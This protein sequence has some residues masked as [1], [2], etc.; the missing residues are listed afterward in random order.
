[1][2]L[3]SCLYY[4]LAFSANKSLSRKR[5]TQTGLSS[6]IAPL[7][8]L[9]T[10]SFVL[11]PSS[12]QAQ[13]A[14]IINPYS[15]SVS[16]IPEGSTQATT[17]TLG[18]PSVF[19]IAVTVSPSGTAYVAA[20]QFS[21]PGEIVAIN[22]TNASTVFSFQGTAMPLGFSSIAV[23]ADGTTIYGTGPDTSG[24]S[25]AAIL[26]GSTLTT[27]SDPNG[28]SIQAPIVLVGTRLFT[29]YYSQTLGTGLA[30]IDLPSQSLIDTTTGDYL[31]ANFAATPD[32]TQVYM[33]DTNGNLEVVSTTS[34]QVVQFFTNNFFSGVVVSP[35]GSKFYV[36]L[37]APNELN[38]YSTSTFALLASIPEVTNAGD[39]DITPDGT[40]VYVVNNDLGNANNSTVQ[41]ISTAT[42]TITAAIPIGAPGTGFMGI[43]IQPVT[44]VQIPSQPG[45][46]L[47]SGISSGQMCPLKC[48]ASDASK[49]GTST[50]GFSAGEPIDI[51]SGNM[52][53]QATD[54]TTAG[55]NPLAFTRSYNSRGN[56]G[57]TT[58][59]K[60]LGINW[61]SN[62]DRYLQL[63]SSQVIAERA[64]GQQLTFT[65]SGSAWTAA[66]DVDATLTHS[67]S[68]WKLKDYNDATE[69]Y[70]ATSAT[71]AQLSTV[72]T[73]NGYMQTLHYNGKKQL[74]TVT[75][76]YNRS[77]ILHY[78]SNGT[79]STVITPDTTTLTYGYTAGG[80]GSN[81]TSITYPTSPPSALTYVY[82]ENG[83]PPNALTGVIDENNNRYAT[84]EYDSNTHA[85]SSQLGTGPTAQIVGVSY[86]D[87][88]NTRT[89]TNPLGVQD[90]YSLTTLQNVPKVTSITRA[91]TNTTGAATRSFTY[92]TN[93]Y[94]ATATDWNGNQT[95][96]TNNAHGMPTKIVEPS[97]TTNIS[98]DPIFVHLP[99]EILTTGLNS[100]FV[101][102]T[103]GNL[104]TRTDED[105]TSQTVPYSTHGQTRT[106]TYTWNNFLL[107]S[108]QN[109]RT[110]VSAIT[111]YGYGPDGALTSITNA[112]SQATNLTQHTGGGRPL[113]IVDPNSVTTTLTYDGCQR[114]TSSAVTTSAG[115]LTTYYTIDPA[116]ELTKVT[117]PDGSFL[118]YAYDTAHRATQVTDTQ[119]NYVKYTLDP[120]GDITAIN[121]Y[122]SSNLLSYRHSA[123]F[124]ALGRMLADV[125]GVGQ[126]TTYSNYD[127]NGNV[128]TITDPLQHETTQLFDALNRLSQITDANKGITK[129]AYDTHDRITKVTDANAHATS[130]V[131]D[132]FGDAIQ[133]TSPDS[134]IT[135]YHYDGDAN[136]TQKVDALSVTTTYAYDKLDRS[137]TRTYPADATQNVT[138]TYDETGTGFGF[139]I[140][141]LG[142][143]AD[144]AG[145][146]SISYD[147][148]GNVLST[149]R[150]STG[151]TNLSNTYYAYDLASRVTAITYP[152]GMSLT[153]DRDTVGNIWKVTVL[154]PGS[155]TQQTVATAAYQP[156]GPI[157][158]LTY[159]DNETSTRK[160]DLDYRMS[161]I[162]DENSTS[163][164]LMDLTYF[165]D[166]A[167]NLKIVQDNVTSGNSQF[168]G[169]DVLNRLSGALGNYGG[170]AWNY[171]KVGTLR[172]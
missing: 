116:S 45:Q 19:P 110:D 95:A 169:Y 102:D 32:G 154:P 75:D 27:I 130:Y 136:L 68:A 119:N 139:G 37:S 44:G 146:V 155:T 105:T 132:G 85:T 28:G 23:S 2:L 46:L 162:T 128:Q 54:Y 83:A 5:R 10:M 69:T 122:N 12:T 124:D 87:G 39:V 88:A 142:T 48:N 148:R 151:G 114:L 106:W 129:F 134:G 26:A 50:G 20:D 66:S 121:T 143:M 168:L 6:R 170:F 91:S 67:G 61:R 152:S 157:N 56:I 171:D 149:Q 36:G 35:D 18:P 22:G 118:A 7:C 111:N 34:F 40:T 158:S 115:I 11:W 81:L 103:S 21:G 9:A 53:Y 78:N 167:N 140:G 127:D 150:Y 55:Q 59:A 49:T 77:L 24:A 156:F 112:L 41:T 160:F 86:D 31:A 58:L 33:T 138:Y 57:V 25:V 153:Y 93:G 161:E 72:Q 62:Y 92:D 84:W 172:L 131:Y 96:Y 166:A 135:V 16:V 76:S 1:V 159:G 42:N 113:T 144:A 109:P 64:D 51:A 145:Y 141:R 30:V 70:L 74:T 14:Y 120:L 137:A 65:L 13:N 89:V 38:V 126:T 133:Q 101:Y 98:Y 80:G 63:S 47:G 90:T 43:F 94:L 147:E 73:R 52:F 29:G 99:H 8:L 97:R 15:S 164:K 82:G 79:L 108:V 3:Q 4:P 123:T 107:A 163:A 17:V 100:T 104:H 117:L 125:G 165:L 71:E 60:T